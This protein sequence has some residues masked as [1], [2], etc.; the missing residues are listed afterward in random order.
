V[1]IENFYS[2]QREKVTFTRQQ[3]SEFAKNIAGD[4]NPIHNENAKRFCVPGDLLFAVSLSKLGV[5][6]N[7]RFDFEGMVTENSE[8]DFTDHGQGKIDINDQNDKVLMHIQQSGENTTEQGF[9]ASLIEKYVAFSGRT[10]PE[11]L[12]ALMKK[13][14]VMINPTR[15]LV[16]YKNMAV[17]IDEFP[18][19]DL[20]LEFTG[21]SLQAEGKKGNV[22]IEFDLLVNSRTIGHGT[23]SLVLGGLREYG[24]AAIDGIVLDYENSKADY[25]KNRT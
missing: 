2:F 16:I 6:Q 11:I 19:G 15:P 22:N 23:K 7:M 4:F 10:F 8:L 18:I 12:V 13:N 9:V 14:Q 17:H 3:A 5:S 1:E 21:A 20:S 24:Q 25:L